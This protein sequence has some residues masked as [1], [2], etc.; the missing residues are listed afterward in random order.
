MTGNYFIV[1]AQLPSLNDFIRKINHN[2]FD[3]ANMKKD[4]EEAIAWGLLEA[5]REGTLR[6]VTEYPVE[7]EI[8][9]HEKDRRRDVDNIKSA[10]KFL[11]D[12][13]TSCGVIKDDGRRY[14]SQIH[15]T[16]I[17]DKETYVV[18]KIIRKDTT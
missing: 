7:L 6:R 3:G 15:D 8:E 1:R 2:R 11:L 4:V 12:A 14:I 17:D 5:K 18:V 10:A 16:V 13:M 9:W